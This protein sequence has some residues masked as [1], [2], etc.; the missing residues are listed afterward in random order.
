MLAG[1]RAV[2]PM[3]LRTTTPS[4]LLDVGCGIGT[5]LRAAL[6]LGI[7]DLIGMGGVEVTPDSDSSRCPL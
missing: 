5:W 7:D 1:R 2:L 6:E 4:S 3:L